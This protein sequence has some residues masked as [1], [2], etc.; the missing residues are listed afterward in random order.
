MVASS[1]IRGLLRGVRSGTSAFPRPHGSSQER[2]GHAVQRSDHQSVSITARQLLDCD[3]QARR[4]EDQPS[5]AC[6]GGRG[7]SG[8]PTSWHGGLPQFRRQGRQQPGQPALGYAVTEPARRSQTWQPSSRR[9]NALQ[10]WS[11]VHAG[12][13]LHQPDEQGAAM[14]RMHETVALNYSTAEAIAYLKS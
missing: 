6:P 7:V 13:H 8:R 5:R 14:S 11:R 9:Q 4:A 12:K 3:A 1:R 2:C 10:T